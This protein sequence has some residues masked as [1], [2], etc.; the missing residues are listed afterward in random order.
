MQYT[1]RAHLSRK[2]LLLDRERRVYFGMLLP[3][4]CHTPVLSGILVLCRFTVFFGCQ[5]LILTKLPTFVCMN[6]PE[7][8]LCPLCPKS[9]QFLRGGDASQKT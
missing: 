5:I 4:I 6:Q 8:F 1:T 2:L 3:R 7:L 9:K